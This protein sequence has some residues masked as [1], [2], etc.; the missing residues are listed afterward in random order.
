M[1]R[2]GQEAP[3]TAA[4]SCRCRQADNNWII[5]NKSTKNAQHGTAPSQLRLAAA[6]LDLEEAPVLPLLLPPDSASAAA[7][8]RASKSIGSLLQWKT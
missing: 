5:T 7:A 1:L 8:A 6:Q 3:R 2:L 4:S